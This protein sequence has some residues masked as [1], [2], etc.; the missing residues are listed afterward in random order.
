MTYLG[1]APDEDKKDVYDRLYWFKVGLC[2]EGNDSDI[3][4][5]GEGQREHS[6]VADQ[7]NEK[8][9]EEGY[10]EVEEVEVEE[11]DCD[12]VFSVGMDVARTELIPPRPGVDTVFEF[13]TSPKFTGD[14]Y[15]PAEVIRALVPKTLGIEEIK[16]LR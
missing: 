9:E 7:A 1:Y 11:E 15:V 4:V 5:G 8:E 12:D 2:M 16:P 14:I 13:V 10:T 6:R 3:E